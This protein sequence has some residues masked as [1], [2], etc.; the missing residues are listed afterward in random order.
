[1]CC[2]CFAS[3]YRGFYAA[4]REGGSREERRIQQGP[5]GGAARRVGIDLASSRAPLLGV[6]EAPQRRVDA[7][8]CASRRSPS[9]FPF[10]RGKQN[11]RGFIW[12]WCLRGPTMTGGVARHP[13]PPDHVPRERL[14]RFLSPLLLPL[15]LLQE[16]PASLNDSHTFNLQDHPTAQPFKRSPSDSGKE[17]ELT[18][19]KKLESRPTPKAAEAGRANQPT[20]P[21]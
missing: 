17:L 4:R 2:F 5:R 9:P 15:L 3:G 20:R 12:S 13:T 19:T 18:L 1:M 6:F 11:S 7:T 21:Q 8:A 14:P 16:A 10:E